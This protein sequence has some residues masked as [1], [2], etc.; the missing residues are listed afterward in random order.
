MAM[1]GQ[2]ASEFLMT[3]GWA[4][5]IAG[6]A[7]ISFFS[8]VSAPLLINNNFCSIDSGPYCQDVLVGSNAF[9]IQVAVLM[10]NTQ[11]YPVY[12]PTLY[13]NASWVGTFTQL[14]QPQIAL[15]GGAILCNAVV[16]RSPPVNGVLVSGSFIASY[17]PCP[18]ANAIACATGTPQSF[19]GQF[20]THDQSYIANTLTSISLQAQN[21]TQSSSSSA[22]DPVTASITILGFPLSGATV[23]FSSNTANAIV[24]PTIITTGSSGNAIAY[25]SSAYPGC[26]LITGNFASTNANTV[27]TFT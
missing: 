3:Y 2:S 1:K 17:V 11:T 24:S 18:S 8:V 16:T 5:L 26:V 7:I 15:P 19:T 6:I 25:V 4:F 22:L 23:T 20:S 12:R 27:I 14:C 9:A 13:M 21:L 10:T